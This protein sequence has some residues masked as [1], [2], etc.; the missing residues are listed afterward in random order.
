MAERGEE[1]DKH[2]IN[3][4]NGLEFLVDFPYTNFSYLRIQSTHCEQKRYEDVL[5]AA[6]DDLL[7]NLA[8]GNH[9][10]IYDKSKR[11][12]SRAIWQGVE[13]ISFVIKL[14]WFNEK[15][16]CPKGMHRDFAQRLKLIDKKELNRIK[17]YRKF[18]SCESIHI[19]CHVDKT[20]HDGDY[21]FYSKT[22]QALAVK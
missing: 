21:D 13:F 11:T 20:L 9:C 8:I 2:Y 10:I 14:L 18:L 1:M 17:Y 5:R 22:V 4:T 19:S 16:I 15:T 7:M 12:E 6:S 3:L